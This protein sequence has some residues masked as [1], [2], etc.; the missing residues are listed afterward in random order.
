MTPRRNASFSTETATMCRVTKTDF[1][2]INLDNLLL[3][4]V[5]SSVHFFPSSD[6]L[7]VSRHFFFKRSIC[8]MSCFAQLECPLF[9]IFR[10]SLSVSRHFFFKR[11]ICCMSCFAQLECPLFPT[12]SSLV[13]S[14]LS[15]RFAVWILRFLMMIVVVVVVDNGL[16]LVCV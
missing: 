8:C 9:P 14:S 7:S 2:I 4:G 15:D 10:L 5:S 11:S 3:L 12:V 13:I 16:M 6:S 1:T